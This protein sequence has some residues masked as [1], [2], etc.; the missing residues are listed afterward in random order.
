VA[1]V[2]LGAPVPGASPSVHA[3]DAAPDAGGA[4]GAAPGAADGS[5]VLWDQTDLGLHGWL[6]QVFTDAAA[7]SGYLVNDVSTGGE[8]WRVTKV[9]TYFT[10]GLEGSWTPESVTTGHLQVYPKSGALPVDLDDVA[11]EHV[12]PVT[13][14]D[15]GGFVWRVE[16]DTSG[17]QELKCISGEFWIGLTP[18]TDYAVDG[19]EYH[20]VTTLVGEETALRNPGGAFGLG[21]GWL[22]LGDADAVAS[23]GPPYETALSLEGEVLVETWVDLGPGTALLSASWGDLP[24]A[25]GSGISCAGSAVTL[26]ADHCGPPFAGTTLVIGLF[27]ISLPFKGGT[28]VPSPDLLLPLP[29]GATGGITLPFN[30]PFGLPAGVTLRLQF[31]QNEPPFSSTNGLE[32]TAL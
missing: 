29:T 12:V 30:W 16:A 8:T 22:S 32:V 13:L 21:S 25:S 14:V 11:P 23:L 1:Q 3:R 6:D 31:W 20:W 27:D 19:Q 17:V 26:S 15:E 7:S 4:A 18:V 28:M 24:T 2:R 9:T 5:V 10:Q